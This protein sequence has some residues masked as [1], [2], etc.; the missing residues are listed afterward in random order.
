[1]TEFYFDQ[2]NAKQ[3]LQNFFKSEKANIS[4]FGNTVNQTFEAAVFAE[5]LKWYKINGWHVDIQ[6]P[7][8]NGKPAFKLKFNTRGAPFKYSYGR[9]TKGTDICQIRHGL[10]I[11]T[12][13]HK[14]TNKKS[15][16]IV[17]DIVVMQDEDIDYF[18]SD[19]ALPNNLLIS[20]GEVKHM[21]A[22]AELVASFIGL[23]HELMPKALKRNRTKRNESPNHIPPFLYVSG[24]LYKTAEGIAETI[25]KRRLKIDIYSFNNPMNNDHSA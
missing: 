1:M 16:N 8:I 3:E 17:S 13:H 6:N 11:H 19:M 10:R 18:E 15:A 2:E 5:T 23:V 4:S 25:R 20:F 21:S 22:Y 9:C 24:I 12:K 7:T 14:P